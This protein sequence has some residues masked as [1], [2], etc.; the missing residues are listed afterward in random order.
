MPKEEYFYQALYT[1]D[2]GQND[3]GAGFFGNMN[4]Q[5]A[6]TLVPDIVNNFSKNATVVQL[7]PVTYLA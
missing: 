4:V 2:I 3:I 7:L 1:F 6:N 5:Q